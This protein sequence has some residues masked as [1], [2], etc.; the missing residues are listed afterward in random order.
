MP[1]LPAIDLKSG[2]ILSP[3]VVILG[4][5]ASAATCPNGDRNKIKLPVMKDFINVVGLKDLLARAGY[6]PD[7]NP[8][9]ED[10]YDSLSRSGAHAELLNELEQRVHK[11]F[12]GVVLPDEPTPYDYLLLGLRRKDVVA[13]FKLGPTAGSGL[14]SEPINART[15]RNG[16]PSWKCGHRGLS[17]GQGQGIYRR[18]LPEMR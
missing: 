17:G 6:N 18:Y 3:H 11:Y 5:G 9:F 13:T 7:S 10:V 4:A 14:P 12:A 16:F 8:N 2:V 15:S 1:T